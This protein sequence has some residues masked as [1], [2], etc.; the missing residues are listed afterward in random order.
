MLVTH[1]YVALYC[2]LSPR[3]DGQAEG[4]DVQERAGRRYAAAHW[5]ELPIRVFRDSLLSASNGGPRPGYDQLRA[6][7]TAGHVAH[8][9]AVE[10]TRLERREIGWFEL[11]AQLDTAGIVDL[12]T[13]RDG[14]VRVRDEVSGIKAVLAAGEV[15][16]MTQRINDRLADNAAQGRPPGATVYGYTHG[17][18]TEGGDKTYLVVPEQAAVIVDSAAKVLAGWTLTSITN[19]LTDRGL[20]GAHGGKFTPSGVRRMLT[21]PTIAGKRVHRGRVVGPGNWQ[22]ILDEGTWSA[23]RAKLAGPRVVDRAGGGT[24]TV[25]PRHRTARRYLLTGYATCGVC[26]A[27]LAGALKQMKNQTK[28]YYQCSPVRGG[29]GCVGILAQPLEQ[30]VVHQLLIEL[31]KPAFRAALAEDEHAQRRGTILAA[32]E[33]AELDRDELAAQWGAAELT[34]G[35]WKAARHTLNVR[36]HQLAADLAE[37]P[38]P[39]THVDPAAIAAGWASM[40]L[41]EQREVIGM[42]VESVTIA[43]ATP[44]YRKF[45]PGRVTIA[46]LAR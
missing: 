9:W 26:G 14:I 41:D 5:P 39:V 29:R 19:A 3:P 22:A 10:Q 20:R 43:R 44:P 2:R 25:A 40:T 23:V 13:D 15:R 4:V 42:F 36:E 11:A 24:Y 17:T 27:P 6:A 31:D 30:H 28:P 1:R 8:L 37:V 32:I 12:H 16:K 34:A 46:W 45:Q 38:P 33:R 7:V 18:T 35:E 21:S